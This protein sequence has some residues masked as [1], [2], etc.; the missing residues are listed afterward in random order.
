MAT[1][2]VILKTKVNKLGYEADIVKVK[3]GYA[4]NFL[5]PQGKALEATQE[6][7][8][9]LEELKVKRAERLSKELAETEKVAAK[10]KKFTPSFDLE[11]GQGGKAFGSVTSIDIHKKLEEAD[12]SI[13]RK[14]IQLD[15]PIKVAGKTDIEISLP[16]D[17]T[18]TL[19]VN[20]VAKES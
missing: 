1:T 16:Q 18:T 9:S 17:V 7:L 13:E 2:Q 4:R 12:I 3:A 20:V 6:N 15:S 14:A 19:T 11:I 10:I 5:V 8:A